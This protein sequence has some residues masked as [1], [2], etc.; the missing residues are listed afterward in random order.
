MCNSTI[1]RVK[2]YGGPGCGKTTNEMSMY[3][4]FL[5]KDYT[6]EDITAITFRLSSATD[7][8]KK[9]MQTANISKKEVSKH[10]GTIH[11]ICN[12][13]SGNQKLIKPK[14]LDD[15][16]QEFGYTEYIENKKTVTKTT[17]GEEET[18]AY[19][20]NLY[21]L[22][23]W[24]RNTQTP[25]EKWF[26][27][28]GTENIILPERKITDFIKDYER[29]KEKIGRIDFSDMLQNV[30]DNKIQLDTPVLMVDEFQDLTAQMYKVFELWESACEYVV[31]AGDPLQ[32]IYGFWGGSPDY[33]KNWKAEEVVLKKSYRL[34][35]QVWDYAKEI[36]RYEGMT[37][38]EITAKNECTSPMSYLDWDD[39]TPSHS[40]ELHLIRCNYQAYSIAMKLAADGKLFGG[41]FGWSS[42]EMNLINAIVSYRLGKQLSLDQMLALAEYYPVEMFGMKSKSKK[43]DL[44]T[45]LGNNYIVKASSL[46]VGSVFI[47]QKLVSALLS[48]DPTTH[49]KNDNKL[50][51]AKIN[52]MKSASVPPTRA[53]KNTK[54][55]FIEPCFSRN[56]LTIHGA[57]GLEA[58][59]VFLHTSITKNIYKNLVIPGEESAA[60]A[61]VWYVGATRAKEKLYIIKDAGKNYPMPEVTA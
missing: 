30:L 33:Y 7:L 53:A 16:A 43:E 15:F 19:S 47:T 50:L 40:S 17:Y 48:E 59:A 10:V 46:Q 32:S 34:P 39:P 44:I 55:G 31:I 38:P 28:P 2:V 41:L 21:D 14:E 29:Y 54:G 1:K 4:T 24:L 11:S 52:G 27:Y 13:L 20:G 45:A 36:L 22:Y 57:K 12:R 60:E 23:T 9:V 18:K 25:A 6:P 37:A 26:M 51:T 8:N 61:R 5:A 42:A 49:M 3:S 58:E 56:I 35:A